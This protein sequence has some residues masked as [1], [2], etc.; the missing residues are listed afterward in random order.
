M[1]ALL[2][3][4]VDKLGVLDISRMTVGGDLYLSVRDSSHKRNKAHHKES[5]PTAQDNIDTLSSNSIKNLAKPV[6]MRFMSAMQP[7][8]NFS[9]GSTLESRI[10][11]SMI[12][13]TLYAGFQN[14]EQILEM[15][16]IID[17][18]EDMA[19]TKS[20]GSVQ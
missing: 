2:T 20:T 10:K 1:Y 15:S 8:K 17:S 9:L 3:Y 13:G 6:N 7:Q 5:L 14:A 4:L 18:D 19:D 12:E 16:E 11:P